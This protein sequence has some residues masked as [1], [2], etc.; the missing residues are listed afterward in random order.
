MIKRLLLLLLLCPLLSNSILVAQDATPINPQ[1]TPSLT[2]SSVMT[3]DQVIPEVDNN[4][5]AIAGLFVN[6]DRD[7][8][9]VNVY[10]NNE[11]GN[12]TQVLIKQ[13]SPNEN[14]SVVL[15]LTEE[16]DGKKINTTITSVTKALVTKLILGELYIE[17]KTDNFNG[18]AA[19]GRLMLETDRSYVGYMDAAQILDNGSDSPARGVVSSHYT[20]QTQ[21]L[22]VNFFASDLSSPI[23]AAYLHYGDA[24]TS[25]TSVAV[26]LTQFV[27]D[28][29][30]FAELDASIIRDELLASNM[31]LVIYT[32]DFP[33]GEIRGQLNYTQNLVHDGWLSGEQVAAQSSDA[34][35]LGFAVLMLNPDFKSCTYWIF[36]EGLDETITLA[37][38][39]NAVPGEISPTI[40]NLNPGISGKAVIGVLT[41]ADMATF[42]GRLLEGLVYVRL[43]TADYPEGKVRGQ[44][45]R[46]A[47]DGHLTSFCSNQVG[48]D[49]D[50]QADGG[51][52][53][54][55]N[56]KLNNSHLIFTS[57]DLSSPIQ[58]VTLNEG[59]FGENGN[60]I[61]DLTALASSSIVDWYWDEDY[62]TSFDATIATNIKTSNAYFQYSTADYPEGE[63]R[64]QVLSQLNCDN[65]FNESADLELDLSISRAHYAQYDTMAFCFTVS[66]NG[67]LAADDIVVDIPLP[68]GF[69]YC[70]ANMSQGEYNLFYSQWEVGTLAPGESASL[71]MVNLAMS[72]GNNINYFAQIANSSA[73]DH[74]STPG[75]DQD[76]TNNEDDEV[77]T[78]IIAIENGGSGTGDFDIDLEL[79]LTVDN[80]QP[81][82]YENVNYTVTI[83]NTGSEF[84]NHI[85]TNVTIP[86]GLAYTSHSFSEGVV[87]LYNGRWFLETLA[88]GASATLDLELFTLWPSSTIP[89]FVQIHSVTE[90]DNDS[91]PGNVYNFIVSEDDEARVNISTTAHTFGFAPAEELAKLNSGEIFPNPTYEKVNVVLQ[92]GIDIDGEVIIYN[93]AGQV[94]IKEFNTFNQGFNQFNYDVS[95]L[96]V[97]TYFIKVK[98][99]NFDSR[100][101]KM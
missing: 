87:T 11:S 19:R 38:L 34:G 64:G 4:I 43:M 16:I 12:L 75:N 74:D 44:M 78:T 92:S 85:V 90:P 31:H 30:I 26:D 72:S 25:A 5:S 9:V 49:I 29:R 88:P 24:T 100:F 36:T 48:G 67:F 101:I 84:A 77:F 95:E 2:I 76:Q 10:A 69:V 22:E 83:T 18:T 7:E 60:Q 80:M 81:G 47:R 27:T 70:Y 20:P 56:R 73:F 62:A 40:F 35:I 63:I 94:V 89:Y 82:P 99:L 86:P 45:Y 46:V 65:N 42:G 91:T 21:K 93:A 14:G 32:E 52:I 39:H 54:S 71:C 15:N 50:S 13:G 51:G 68:N 53:I 37:R 17:I 61:L 66:N 97:G 57:H 79:D 8:I 41:G 59:D 6:A 33:E 96:P 98:E 28:S 58:S 3:S 23:T 55:I 1:F